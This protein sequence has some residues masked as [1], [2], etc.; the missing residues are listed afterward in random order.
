VIFERFIDVLL[1]KVEKDKLGKRGKTKA[2]RRAG[3]RSADAGE[4]A[5]GTYE[6][7]IRS[8]TDRTA[9]TDT[10]RGVVQRKALSRHIPNGVRRAVWFRDRGQCAFVA[11]SGHRC[12]E[13]SFLELHHIHPYALE[14]PATIGNISLRCRRH[15]WYEAEIVFRSFA[16]P[17]ERTSER[18]APP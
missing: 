2:S 14:G 12:S 3:R 10:V 6:N 5:G 7:R 8:G 11:D 4:P 18:E 9:S 15:N 13:Q 16:I 1:D 17:A